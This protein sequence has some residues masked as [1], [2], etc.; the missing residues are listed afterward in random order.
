MGFLRRHFLATC[1]T[2]LVL[3]LLSIT[4]SVS[5]GSTRIPAGTVWSIVLHKLSLLPVTPDWSAGRENIVWDLRLPRALLAATVGA[6]LG[7]AGAVMQ[8]VTR[9]PLADPHL[10]GVSAGAGFG[11]NLA[12][13]AVG[14]LLGVLTVPLF[15]FAGALAATAIVVSVAGLTHSTGPTRLVLAGLA[16]SFVI[17]AGSNVLIMLADPR[18]ISSVVFWMLG[19]FGFAQWNNLAFPALAL[20]LSGAVF[21]RCAEQL[22]ALSMGDESAATLGVDVRRLR[23]AMLTVSA[24]LT[25]VLVAFSGMIGFVGLMMPHVA[26]L[27][28]GGDN[29]RVLPASALLGAI[30]LILADVLA[31]RLTAPNDMPIGVVTGL[32]GGLFFIVLLARQRG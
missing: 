20:L 17:A 31:R 27:L 10:L 30:F 29:R 5:I 15:A 26:R 22:N 1:I 8:G 7:I 32:I 2:G 3:C 9:N 18:A 23:I 28:I 12:M 14:N 13:L 11:A 25:G 16:V 6:G 21:L 24:F 19:G 4:L